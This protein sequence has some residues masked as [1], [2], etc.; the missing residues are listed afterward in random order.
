MIKYRPE[1]DGLRTIAVFAVILFHLNPE[2]LKGGYYG[3]DVFFVIS[4]YLITSHLTKEIK[5]GELSLLKFWLR[6]VK[7]LL[8]TLLTVILTVLL[9]AQFLI[10]KTSFLNTLNDIFPATFSY[11]NFHAYFNYGDYWGQKAD[12]SFFL[13]TWS[14]SLEEQ[15]YLIYP[16]LLIFIYRLKIHFF[17]ALLFFTFTSFLIFYFYLPIN[18]ERTFYMLPFRFWELSSGGLLSLISTA[19]FSTK[20]RNTLTL[21]GLS[22]I[23]TSFIFAEH[24]I[25]YIILLPI[26]G[27][28]L[29]IAFC[30]TNTLLGKILASKSF[31]HFGKLSYSMYLWHW[32]LIVLFKNLYLVSLNVNEVFL[33]IIIFFITYIL[34]FITYNLVENKTRNFKYTPQIVLAS[35]AIIFCFFLFFKSDHY[36]KHYISSFNK[37]TS[38]SNYYCIAPRPDSININDPILY[39]TKVFRRP[40]E[41]DNAYSQEGITERVNGEN[42]KII[43]CGDSHGTMWA[44]TIQEIST[45]LSLSSSIYTANASWPFIN[46]IDLNDQEET[47]YF[48]KEE[49]I[50][51]A[52][53]LVN[54]IN[55]WKPKIFI[56]AC[57]WENLNKKIEGQLISLLEFLTKKNIKVLII[58]Q[59]P[60]LNFMTNLNAPQYLTYL[61]FKPTNGFN[62]IEV[63]DQDNIIKANTYL[64]SLKNKFNT[65]S[66]F[67]INS[68]LL[69][70]NKAKVSYNEDVIYFDEDH[71]SHD[72]TLLFKNQLKE[73][74]KNI[75]Q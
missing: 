52:K 18:Q 20:F 72:G 22:F 62:I 38:Y 70:N 9:I 25:S 11:F 30:N 68:N 48:T 49:R 32:P 51:Y 73:F 19:H 63:K 44:K 8:P 31:V 60:V 65:I 69:Q 13:H 26:I 45:E 4:G 15:F 55:I 3:V 53:S 6:R 54:N 5:N 36:S 12:S 33:Y 2:L 59:P 10:F 66:I 61:E 39:N 47:K 46:L 21:I 67:D 74:I 34:S 29:I 1:I 24:T 43:L 57:R 17:K 58:N 23:L 27:C 41:F 40:K 35:I 7:R 50:L 42:P 64:S 14:L 75:L 56:L 71:L 37:Q 28:S 16:I